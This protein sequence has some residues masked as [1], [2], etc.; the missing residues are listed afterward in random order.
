MLVTL[1]G[2]T[3]EPVQVSFPVTMFASM[4][5]KPP[6]EQAMSGERTTVSPFHVSPDAPAVATVLTIGPKP[7]ADAE[8]N[9]TALLRTPMNAS[10]PTDGALPANMTSRSVAESLNA[11]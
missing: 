6:P 11:Y 8:I 4:V 10:I 5:T 9:A 1:L 7:V 3:T 2:I